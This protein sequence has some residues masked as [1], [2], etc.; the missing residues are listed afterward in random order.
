MS[1]PVEYTPGVEHADEDET[2]LAA[3]LAE[4][5]LSISRKTYADSHHGTRSVH[6]KS[7]ALLTGTLEVLDNP[8]P[9]A[10]GLFARPERYSA[11]IRLSTTPGDFLPDSVSTPRGLAVKIL[12]VKRSGLAGLNGAITQD[13]VMVNGP[14][15][16][17]ANARAFLNGLKMLAPTT[18]RMEGAKVAASAVLRGTE[19]VIE[20][21]GGRSITVRALG[22]EPPVNPLGETYYSQT[23]LRYGDYM[24]KLS[25]APV[26]DELTDL[27]GHRLNLHHS[28]AIREAMIDHFA[29]YGGTWEVRAQ[30][31]TSLETMPIENAA[32]AWPEDESP[33]V[34]VARL[35]VEPQLAWSHAKSEAIDDGM[36]F[37][38]WHCLEAHQ[39]LGSINR[40]RRTAYAASA[41]FRAGHNPQPMQEPETLEDAHLVD[42]DAAE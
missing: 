37:S 9:F 8:P 35:I 19:S 38:P 5:L 30:L 25:I 4:T 18:D 14:V 41:R 31:C 10:Q 27:K 40:L 6:A 7:H 33:Y 22:G 32:K 20:H 23:P 13:L 12:G 29:A 15:F 2:Q 3:E 21:L 1:Q 39:P 16:Q 36:S 26:S 42:S 11:I 24:A 28:L 17:T 34:A